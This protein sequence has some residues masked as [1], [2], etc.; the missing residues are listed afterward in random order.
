MARFLPRP[1][2]S[3]NTM[4]VKTPPRFV[5]TDAARFEIGDVI[6]I[7]GFYSLDPRTLRS[8][9]HLDQ[10]VVRRIPHRPTMAG[11]L[12]LPEPELDDAESQEAIVVA[13]VGELGILRGSCVGDVRAH[14]RGHVRDVR[15][16]RLGGRIR[17]RGFRR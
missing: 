11:E 4:R 13:V 17:G 7:D 5:V 6:T 3:A 15:G 10:L 1:L 14:V 2:P 12:Y 8:T 16:I 9:G